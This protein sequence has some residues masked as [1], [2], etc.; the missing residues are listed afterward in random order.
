MFLQKP[1]GERYTSDTYRNIN[2]S[3][4]SDTLENEKDITIPWLPFR[5]TLQIQLIKNDI[6]IF[7]ARKK[8][9]K[10]NEV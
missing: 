8:I 9:W 6:S 7:T 2:A 5:S 1:T 4:K 10:S 3:R